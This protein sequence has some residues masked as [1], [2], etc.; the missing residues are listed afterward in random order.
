MHWLVH[1][2]FHHNVSIHSHIPFPFLTQCAQPPIHP[3]THPPTYSH[4]VID[5]PP[6]Y[7]PAYPPAFN[8]P[9]HPLTHSFQPTQSPT[10]FNRPNHPLTQPLTLPNTY[11]PT[12]PDHKSTHRVQPTR[13]Q[14]RQRRNVANTATIPRSVTAASHHWT[15]A[16]TAITTAVIATPDGGSD[17]RDSLADGRYPFLQCTICGQHTSELKTNGVVYTRERV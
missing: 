7:P 5:H 1:S 8:Q 13:L 16:T 6:A 2:S 3:T 17:H 15:A 10:A 12:H 4:T 14:S 11:P 9:N